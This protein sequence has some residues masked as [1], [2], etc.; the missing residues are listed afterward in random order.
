ML[1]KEA[2]AEVCI[3]L[4]RGVAVFVLF[5]PENQNDLENAPKNVL[6]H[7]LVH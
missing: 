7:L 6:H 4:S 5:F 3:R 2:G 1:G